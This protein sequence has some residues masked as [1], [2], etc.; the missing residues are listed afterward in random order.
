[1]ENNP[2]YRRIM[3]AAE[4]LF[5]R[6]GF[7]AVTMEAVA[8]EAQVS[9]ATLYGH[10]KNKDELFHGVC[11][12]L[13]TL[14]VRSFTEALAVPGQTVDERACGALVA[15][16]TLNLTLIQGSPHAAEFSLNASLAGDVFERAEIE[17]VQALTR[18]LAEDP[19][20]RPTAD[21]LARTLFSGARG[22]AA[23]A[24]TVEVLE[25]ELGRFVALVLA[26]ARA[27]AASRPGRRGK[28][29]AIVKSA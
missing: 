25:E 17:K 5:K 21:E 15:K 3:R 20:L 18:T 23:D 11:V 16:Y 7:R 29:M 19:T 13:A 9:K 26:G 1:V 22:V 28:P 10:F 27:Q 2:L 8:R 14:F 12:R 24:P 4:A 6:V